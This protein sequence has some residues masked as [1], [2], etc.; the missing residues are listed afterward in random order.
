[1]I[2]FGKFTL[3]I[4]IKEAVINGNGSDYLSKARISIFLDVPMTKIK[5]VGV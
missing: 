2:T 5:N 4:A 3:V 1:M